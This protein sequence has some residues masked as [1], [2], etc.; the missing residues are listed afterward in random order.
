METETPIQA[1]R[2]TNAL[3]RKLILKLIQD[4]VSFLKIEK[5]ETIPM[6]N[7]TR[8]GRHEVE[9]KNSSLQKI[10]ELIFNSKNF[11]NLTHIDIMNA[12]LGVV[13]FA[14]EP[15]WKDST[16]GF[17]VFT[18]GWIHDA[19]SIIVNLGIDESM[20]TIIGGDDLSDEFSNLIVELLATLDAS[21]GKLEWTFVLRIPAQYNLTIGKESV[22]GR[23]EIDSHAK[24]IC[25]TGKYTGG[26]VACERQMASDLAVIFALLEFERTI[27]AHSDSSRIRMS[28]ES[29]EDAKIGLQ[30]SFDKKQRSVAF[31]YLKKN[32]DEHASRFDIGNTNTLHPGLFQLLSKSFGRP[33]LKTAVHF[34]HSDKPRLGTFQFLQYWCAIETMLGSPDQEIGKRLCH[35]FTLILPEK[36]EEDFWHLYKIRNNIVHRGI[37]SVDHQDLWNA[38]NAA[39]QIF[40]RLF[41]T[42]AHL[43]D[44]HSDRQ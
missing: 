26:S 22:D 44:I 3:P 11:P 29:G 19:E 42:V 32:Y 10:A 38:E 30:F 31:A 43:K 2:S 24:E 6:P 1:A 18:D 23:V 21:Y 5:E 8:F 17:E 25:I 33:I 28:T 39:K 36:T 37:L 20:Q 13:R 35:A 34:F 9:Q 7:L 4:A 40:Y 15:R 14:V 41:G 16:S 27:V 12:M